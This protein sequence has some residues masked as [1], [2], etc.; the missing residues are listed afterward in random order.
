MVATVADPVARRISTASTQASRM[1][2]MLAPLAHS[3][4]TVPMPVS[5]STCLNPPPAATIRM[6]PATGGSADSRHLAICV[7]GHAGAA[8]EGEHADD[9][10]DQQRDQRRAEDVE[11]LPEQT[12]LV[13]DE[14]VD[15]RLAQHQHDRQ[16]HAEQRDAEA[17]GARA[18]GLRRL[19]RRSR[20]RTLPSSA[21]KRVAAPR[22]RPSGRRACRTAGRRR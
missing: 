2:E 9:H 21:S 13:V 19:P 17:D 4:S 12:V 15:E 18:C 14:D 7:A 3:A 10:R 22:R 20:R 5:T 6:M 1:T 16:Q 8:A 11:D